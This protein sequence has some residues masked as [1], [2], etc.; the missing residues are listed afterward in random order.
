MDTDGN[1]DALQMGFPRALLLGGVSS[2]RR[3]VG[4][5]GGH[6]TVGNSGG[7]RTVGHIGAGLGVF[8]KFAAPPLGHQALHDCVGRFGQPNHIGRGKC[9]EDGYCHDN[10][11]EEVTG[12]TERCTKR[13]ENEGELANLRQ[14][15][16]ALHGGLQRLSCQE[17]TARAE[18]GLPQD[19]G[20]DDAE[21]GH[22]VLRDKGHIDHHTDGNK[23]DGAEEILHRTDQ[24]LYL[25]SLDGLGQYTAHDEGTKRSREAD[26]RGYHDH[27][28]TE[29]ECRDEQCLVAH[30]RFYLTQEQRYEIDAHDKPEDEEEGELQDGHDHL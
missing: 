12:D 29:G 28:E 1:S 30:Q 19:D 13:G 18:N 17:E 24:L 8:L 27:A 23:E 15:E 11:I 16:G 25:F 14:R 26:G 22:D 9:G 2:R 3:T 7:R 6:R 21:D 5:S 4:N 20:N 10:G